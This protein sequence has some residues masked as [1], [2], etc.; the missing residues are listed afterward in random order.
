MRPDAQRDLLDAHGG[1]G[2]LRQ[3]VGQAWK[4]WRAL[5]RQ[6]EAA[7]KTPPAWPPNA[8]ACNGRW[9]NS[10]AWTWARTRDALQSEH[11]RLA[12]AQSL[13]DGAGQIL[14]ALDGDGDSAHH[15]LNSAGQ[16]LQQMLRH[17]PG[18]QGVVD[19]IES[20]RI[21]VSEAVSD[22]NNYV[23]RVDLD[24]Q[25]LADVEARLSAVFE[26]A[27]K[28]RVEPDGLC[29]L[30]EDLHTQLSALQAAADID[31]LRDD[32]GRQSRYDAAGARHGPAQ[33]RQGSRQA[34]QAMQT[35][36]MQGAASS[37]RCHP[38][39]RPRTATNRSLVAGHAGTSPRPPA[40]T[41]SSWSARR[42]R[43]APP[44]PASALD[45]APRR[46]NRPHAGRHQAH[47]HHPRA[48]A[49][50][51]GRRGPGHTLTQKTGRQ[52]RLSLGAP[53]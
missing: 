49:R 7:E 48:R 40:P 42:N 21:A 51:A 38:R 37:R 44:G 53:R 22:L 33:G 30:R 1:H 28:F 6:L 8:N 36:A 10:T 47:R 9:K 52:G 23:S 34:G 24:P 35:L 32:P 12:H 2:E 14:E 4:L 16:R 43:A 11:T 39:R 26:T 45:D 29:G 18:L 13:L 19:E 25:R 46:G 5:A 3:A 20:A 17:D 41:A 15:R 50:N 31:S 27:R